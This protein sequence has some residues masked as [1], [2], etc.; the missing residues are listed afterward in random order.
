MRNPLSA[1]HPLRLIDASPCEKHLSTLAGSCVQVKHTTFG[2]VKPCN[3]CRARSLGVFAKRKRRRDMTYGV[4]LAERPLWATGFQPSIQQAPDLTEHRTGKYMGPNLP[5]RFLAGRFH[6]P[7]TGRQPA[8]TTGLES[9]PA[10]YRQ[11]R[12][13]PPAFTAPYC[14]FHA[15]QPPL[16]HHIVSFMHNVPL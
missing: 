7:C 15:P 12:S 6:R 11:C 3:R 5:A 9:G 14:Y 1:P 16:L 10:P 2:D 13:T 4:V 8:Y